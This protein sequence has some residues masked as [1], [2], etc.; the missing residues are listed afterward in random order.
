MRICALEESQTLTLL[1]V[2]YSVQC[3][4]I[5]FLDV[6]HRATEIHSVTTYIPYPFLV[7]DDLEARWRNLGV[8]IERC[9]NGENVINIIENTCVFLFETGLHYIP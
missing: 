8:G 2:I 5:S 1:S 3:L 9:Q 7:E 6:S 4:K